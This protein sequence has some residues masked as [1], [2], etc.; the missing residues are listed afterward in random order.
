MFEG[1]PKRAQ[2]VPQTFKYISFG[3]HTIHDCCH[4][5]SEEPFQTEMFFGD[6][7]NW[8]EIWPGFNHGKIPALTNTF[9]LLLKLSKYDLIVFQSTIQHRG[10]AFHNWNVRVHLFWESIRVVR[11]IDVSFWVCFRWQH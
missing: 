6:H 5:I 8:F 2:F 10:A 4:T 11:N 7:E 9:G 3:F 1:L